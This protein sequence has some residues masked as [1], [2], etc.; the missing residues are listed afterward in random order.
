MTYKAKGP[1]KCVA[2]HPAK[3]EAVIQPT[4][5]DLAMMAAYID[6]EGCIATTIAS[7][8]KWKNPSLSIELSVHNTDPRLMD[9]CQKRFGGRIYKTVHSRKDWMDSYGWKVSCKQAKEVLEQCLPYFIIKREQAEL[10]I[11]LE[12]TKARWGRSG[13][14]DH[15]HRQRWEI[16]NQLSLLK[17]KNAR[18]KIKEPDHVSATHYANG[19]KKGDS[20][21]TLVN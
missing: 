18:M 2:R 1:S 4:E 3:R 14:P 20:G 16:R 9:W 7:T 11:A 17:G 5:I 15:V 6:G 8:T 21:N 13:A 19:A 12:S 10:A